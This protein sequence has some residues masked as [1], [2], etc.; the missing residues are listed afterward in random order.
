[1]ST[2][3]SEAAIAGGDPSSST[4]DGG[5]RRR[6][7]GR[8]HAP[9]PR[10]VSSS[11]RSPD[12]SVAESSRAAAGSG[13]TASKDDQREQRERGTST[14]S[15]VPASCAATA[16]TSTAHR[17]QARDEDRSRVRKPGDVGVAV[18]K[19]AELAVRGLDSREDVVLA[20]VRDELR[21]SAE[22]LDEFGRQLPARGRPGAR[23]RVVRVDERRSGHADSAECEPGREHDRRSG[24][25]EP[26]PRRRKQP[27]P[28]ARRNGGARPR[29]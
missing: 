12:A 29:R 11:T 23:R 17:R 19:V 2:D 16:T 21:R 25:H 13:D 20:T 1:M 22:E 27:L 18:P 9:A 28:R 10:S 14:R 8:V 7:I 5:L 26:P 3:G 15:S 6:W 4:T 24:E